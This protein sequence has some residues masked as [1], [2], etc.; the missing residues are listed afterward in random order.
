[1]ILDAKACPNHF[2]ILYKSLVQTNTHIN[3]EM[4][5]IKREVISGNLVLNKFAT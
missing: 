4:V 2:I 1:M 3:T 5:T